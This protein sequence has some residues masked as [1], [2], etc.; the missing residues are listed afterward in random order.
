MGEE[1][2]SSSQDFREVLAKGLDPATEKA[3]RMGVGYHHAGMTVE[4]RE[5]VEEAFRGG[6]FI[7]F[8]G[9]LHA[10]SRCESSS[11]QGD[12]SKLLNWM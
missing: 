8:G 10:G 7:D 3:V 6:H 2:A 12:F 1:E 5:L 4:E 9:N 11:S